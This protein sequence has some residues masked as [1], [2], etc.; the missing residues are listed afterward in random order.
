MGAKALV[1]GFKKEGRTGGD[2]G[3]VGTEGGETEDSDKRHTE[4]DGNGNVSKLSASALDQIGAM[5]NTIAI[6]C[7]RRL[8]L[9]LRLLLS[10]KAAEKIV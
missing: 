8:V 2:S 9:W 5:L 10:E 6:E 4:T 7:S 3:D 1:T